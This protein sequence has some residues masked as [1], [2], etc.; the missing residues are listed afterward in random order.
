MP[1]RTFN[2]ILW[3]GVIAL[4][5]VLAW[6]TR[7]NLDSY[8]ARVGTLEVRDA[9]EDNSVVMRWSGK[10]NAP[11]E[12]RIVET[13]ER[14]KDERRRFVLTLSSPGGSLEHGAKVARRLR[15]ISETHTLETV[16]EAGRSCASMCVP[17]YLQGTRRT[18]AP[19]AKFMFHEVSFKEYLSREDSDVPESAKASE[20]DRLFTTY[21]AA[22]GVPG[23][24]IRRVRASMTGG[25]D[26]WKTAQ[27]L[28]DENAGIVL[29]MSE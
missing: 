19:D 23:A 9:P 3:T 16:V 7:N 12:S 18:A 11:M 1:S 2:R 15:Q 28:I 24:W 17:I 25:N 4:L 22:A 8:F 26:I 29:Q 5:A 20:T 6:T 14:Y 10:I 13:F 27:E 21:F